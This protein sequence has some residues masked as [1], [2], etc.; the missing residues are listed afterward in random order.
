MCADLAELSTPFVNIRWFM[1]KASLTDHPFYLVNGGLMAIV[2]FAC[3]IVL[4]L[5]LL[6]FVVYQAW[7]APDSNSART[8]SE[9]MGVVGYALGPL[10]CLFYLLWSY[11]FVLIVTGIKA[12]VLGADFKNDPDQEGGSL[13]GRAIESVNSPKETKKE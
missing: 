13:V 6:Y 9:H 7:F 10:V 11:W 12:A 1:L 8:F 4:G 5:W 3:R 2:F